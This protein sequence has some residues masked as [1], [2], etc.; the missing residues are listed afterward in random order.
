M[1]PQSLRS[2]RLELP[3]NGFPDLVGVFGFQWRIFY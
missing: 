2:N 1:H 3:L